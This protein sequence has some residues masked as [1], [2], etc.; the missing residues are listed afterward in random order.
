M[1]TL[2][3]GQDVSAQALFNMKYSGA[4]ALHYHRAAESEMGK[5]M[6]WVDSLLFN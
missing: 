5:K 2:H 3:E 4:F 6:P 1:S